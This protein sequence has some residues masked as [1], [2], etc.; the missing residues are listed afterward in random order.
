VEHWTHLLALLGRVDTV[1]GPREVLAAVAR[2]IELIT[3]YRDAARGGLRVDLMRVES[4]WCEFAAWLSND[5]G[6]TRSRD[7]WTDRAASLA[8]TTG[9]ADMAALARERRAQWS[10][11]EHNARR[12]IAFA[13]DALRIPGTSAQTRALCVRQAACGHALGGDIGAC[14][15]RL[16]EVEYIMDC[17]DA[18][19]PPWTG[20]LVD[21]HLVRSSAARCWLALEPRKAVALYE[22]VLRDWPRERVRTGGLHQARYALACAVTGELDRARA[23]GRKAAAVMRAT[24][25]TGIARELQRLGQVLTAA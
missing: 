14:E 17:A 25:S 9:Y 4:R 15:R 21:H 7:A 23:E 20:G 10:A 8:Q 24:K 19:E 16:A 11:Q 1:Y 6:D 12:T 5:T 22:T 3:A 2:E 18:T 13:E